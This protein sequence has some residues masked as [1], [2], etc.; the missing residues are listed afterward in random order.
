MKIVKKKGK[1]VKEVKIIKEVKIVLK[2]TWS[3]SSWRFA[4]GDVLVEDVPNLQVSLNES[5]ADGLA[6]VGASLAQLEML[7]HPE[8]GGIQPM[9][10]S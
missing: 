5:I 7:L 6:G 9:L 4:C 3:D 2:V 1:I 8:E 10:I